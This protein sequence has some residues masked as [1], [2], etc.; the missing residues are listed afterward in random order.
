MALIKYGGGVVQ[1][2][3]SIAGQTHARNRYGNYVRARTKPINPRSARQVAVRAALA[4]LTARWGQTLTAVQR[5][6]W[7]L[8]GSSVSM[9]NKLSASIFLTGFNHYIRSNA[10]LAHLGAATIDDG[11]VIFEIP[12]A[13]PLFSGAISEATNVW[14]ITFND[15]LD[16]V[17][18]DGAQM[19][20]YNG[21]PQN[22]QRNFFAGPWRFMNS[23]AG[24]NG[25][26]PV[27]P[28]DRAASFTYTELQH[29]WIYARIMRADGRLSAPFRYDVFV[30]A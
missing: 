30:G 7:N 4:F 19:I 18:E 27:S 3:G 29:A 12:E 11:P 6:A 10:W 22:P 21:A 1:M 23:I 28:L 5:A 8:Y 2:S 20:M 26:P 9:T 16:W 14:T 13:D 25:A 17:S 24:N 15:A